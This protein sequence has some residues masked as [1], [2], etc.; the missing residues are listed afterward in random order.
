MAAS[1]KFIPSIW[2]HP[3]SSADHYV[4]LDSDSRLTVR[5]EDGVAFL[6]DDSQEGYDLIVVDASDPIGPGA[7]LYSDNFYDLLRRRLKPKGA[8][9]VQVRRNIC[10]LYVHIFTPLIVLPTL[11]LSPVVPKHA[12]LVE[13][14]QHPSQLLFRLYF[15]ASSLR[16]VDHFGICPWCSGRCFTA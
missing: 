3:T 16:R 8:V 7:A 12:R 9:A 6:S 5:A 4:P 1:K 11:S 10:L 15:L 14:S 13:H 2:R